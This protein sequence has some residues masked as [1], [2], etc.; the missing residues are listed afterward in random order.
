MA[1]SLSAI[2]VAMGCRARGK[3]ALRG[4]F[5]KM[6]QDE[7]EDDDDDD[8]DD[9]D[10]GHPPSR[11]RFPGQGSTYDQAGG[12]S[13]PGSVAAPSYGAEGTPAGSEL[14]SESDVDQQPGGD[15]DEEEE[16]VPLSESDVE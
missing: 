9:D 13:A 16:D 11:S 7:D 14:H 8:D 1:T 5:D 10:F 6:S 15:E 2:E 3:S 12:Y 4:E